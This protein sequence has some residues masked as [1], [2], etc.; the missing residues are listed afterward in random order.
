MYKGTSPPR[1]APPNWG[2]AMKLEEFRKIPEL[3]KRAK[4]H[5]DLAHSSGFTRRTY[6][7]Y[8]HASIGDFL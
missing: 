7:T 4:R 6:L 1:G 3:I 2:S 5:L 8:S